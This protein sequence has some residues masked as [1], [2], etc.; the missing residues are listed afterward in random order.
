M[1]ISICNSTYRENSYKP[2]ACS[3]IGKKVVTILSLVKKRKKNT[4]SICEGFIK[5]WHESKIHEQCE[6]AFLKTCEAHAC[7][8]FFRSSYGEWNV[9][10]LALRRPSRKES[11]GVF[12]VYRRETLFAQSN[13]KLEQKQTRKVVSWKTGHYI[14]RRIFTKT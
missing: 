13:A 4:F 2:G 3:T 11:L 14:R 6:I 7:F 8:V 5:L 1:K 10:C 12:T 9:K